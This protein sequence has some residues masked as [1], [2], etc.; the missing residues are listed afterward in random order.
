LFVVFA[1]G[2][3][4]G[5]EHLLH[6]VPGVEDYIRTV[7][8]IDGVEA[9]TLPGDPERRTLADRRANGIPLDDGNWAA[10]VKLAGEL[11]VPLP[12]AG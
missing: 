7:P 10:L 1:P 11:H 6:Q 3:L 5:L 12:A 9:I 2:Q 4:G 8:R